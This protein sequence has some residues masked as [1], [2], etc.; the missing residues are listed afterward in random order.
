MRSIVPHATNGA[1]PDVTMTHACSVVT[2]R[3]GQTNKTVK[4]GSPLAATWR[5]GTPGQLCAMGNRSEKGPC[6]F[7]TGNLFDASA[8]RAL[9]T[10]R[11]SRTMACRVRHWHQG[12]SGAHEK[13]RDR[14]HPRCSK[15]AHFVL[16]S[17]SASPRASTLGSAGAR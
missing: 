12:D 6:S 7:D 1:K 13:L 4:G 11:Q 16:H 9:G 10:G 17:L 2:V 15:L 5:G 3:I 8:A 14:E